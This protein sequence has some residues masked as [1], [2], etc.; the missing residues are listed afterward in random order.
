MPLNIKQDIFDLYS[1]INTK[2]IKWTS[3]DNLHITVKFIGEINNNQLKKL[4][5]FL[6]KNLK[7][8]N[9]KLKINNTLFFPRFGNPKII[10][11]R[12]IIDK[13]TNREINHFL[14]LLHQKLKFIPKNDH[15]FTPHITIG[16]VK[17]YIDRPITFPEKKVMGRSQYEFQ[18]SNECEINSIELMQSTLTPHGPIY[19]IIKSYKL[20]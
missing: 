13:K 6:E 9:C 8:E 10:G 11:L 4:T 7:F 5:S 15:P 20:K 17:G 16:R 1:K 2:T 18:Y 14:S 19:N 12:G 3:F